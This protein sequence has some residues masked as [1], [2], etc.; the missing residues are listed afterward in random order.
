MYLIQGSNE[1]YINN[2]LNILDKNKTIQQQ[3]NKKIIQIKLY[4]QN[5]NISKE[6]LFF[7]AKLKMY[8]KHPLILSRLNSFEFFTIKQTKVKIDTHKVLVTLKVPITIK[9]NNIFYRVISINT[10]YAI[11]IDGILLDLETLE[12]LSSKN[13]VSGYPTISILNYDGIRTNRLLHRLISFAWVRNE[14]WVKFNIVNHIDGNKA[15]YAIPNLEWVDYKDNNIHAIK[16]GLRPAVKPIMVKNIKTGVIVELRSI[17]EACEYMGRSRMSTTYS[18]VIGLGKLVYG[19]NGIYELKYIDDKT[20][21]V[22]DIDSNKLITTNQRLKFHIHIDNLKFI[23]NTVNDINNVIVKYLTPKITFAND[24]FKNSI[25]KF[26]RNYKTIP[27]YIEYVNV[28]VDDY[29][30][31]NTINNNT[32]IVKNRREIIDLTNGSKSAIQKAIATNGKYLINGWIVKMNDGKPHDEPVT[33]V[34]KAI[35]IQAHNES[36]NKTIIFDSFRKAGEYFYVDKSSIISIVKS[37]N[38]IDGYKLTKLD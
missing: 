5:I 28:K 26:I 38:K 7:I 35:R 19:S 34:N 1:L 2:N 32:K 18:K 25:K 29:I 24:E 4:N 36:L 8:I 21:W 31:I 11:S 23:C 30:C 6:S 15:N 20:P 10:R 37:K 12:T 22:S 9:Y 33:I 16:N 17:T 13:K 27:T 3:Y 14:D